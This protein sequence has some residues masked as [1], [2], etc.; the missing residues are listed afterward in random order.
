MT[1]IAA[2]AL[3]SLCYGFLYL[4]VLLLWAP[5]K[6]KLPLWAIT[7][8][9][10]IILG[11]A[12]QQ[13]SAIAIIP[14]VLLGFAAYYS[15]AARPSDFVRFFASI[16]LL[17]LGLGLST[18]QIP[19]FNSLNIINHVYFTKDAIPF[20]LNLS[21]DKTLIGIFILGF[22]HELIKSKQ[23]WIVMVKQ[24]ALRAVL[25]VFLVMIL[26]VILG[27]VRFETKFPHSFWIWAVTNFLFVCTAEEAF[28]RGFIQKNLVL[29]MKKR[30]Y[31]HYL[32]IGIAAVI[33]GLAHSAGGIKYMFLVTMAGVG[34]GWIYDR[35]KRI[36]AS[37]LTHFSLNI[38]HFL[39]FTYPALAR[40]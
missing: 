36:E 34:F 6:N 39:F 10:A 38:M 2:H 18:H 22:S 40:S 15:Q 7:L 24:T 14:I 33:F 19:G 27:F 30:R 1:W 35:T 32:A 11:F 13:L 12:S 28:F 3:V 37:I 9:I 4:T 25:I 8:F 20:T 26:A 23:E 29:W 17:L 31:G 16:F 21:L 5:G